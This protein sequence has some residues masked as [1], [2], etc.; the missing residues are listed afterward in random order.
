VNRAHHGQK[1]AAGGRAGINVLAQGN[2]VD[3][4]LL[5]DSDRFE[6]VEQRS[7]HAAQ[8]R[9]NER[10]TRTDVFHQLIPAGAIHTRAGHLVGEDFPQPAFPKAS[11]WESRFWPTLLTRA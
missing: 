1:A 11:I 2:Q 9:D 6:E 8:L 3:P 4:A 10:I 5:Q 7:R